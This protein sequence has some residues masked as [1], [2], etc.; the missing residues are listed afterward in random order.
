M[1]NILSKLRLIF[2]Q[3]AAFFPTRLPTGMAEF[4]RWSDSIIFLYGKD[5]GTASQ[6]DIRFGLA[7]A[8]MHMGATE[9]RKPKRF[10]GKLLHKGAASQIAYAVMMDLKAKQEAAAKAAKQAE[11][12]AFSAVPGENK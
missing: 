9:S 10:F 12:M 4:A 5:I 6:D 7:G 11:V 1:S 2:L 8:V 3:A